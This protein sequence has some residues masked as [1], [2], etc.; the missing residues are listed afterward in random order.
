MAM[1]DSDIPYANFVERV[2]PYSSSPKYIRIRSCPGTETQSRDGPWL[3]IPV[4][5]YSDTYFAK[6]LLDGTR[7][8]LGGR[9]LISLVVD[10]SSH[11][12]KSIWR[13]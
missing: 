7:A 12:M 13:N 10:V 6:V 5:T 2:K 3:D 1:Q 11:R 8:C 4:N 9:P